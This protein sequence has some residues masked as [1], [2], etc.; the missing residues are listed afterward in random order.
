[1]SDSLTPVEEVTS[2]QLP[3]ASTLLS[4]WSDAP[5][6]SNVVHKPS[7]EIQ[8]QQPDA[9]MDDQIVLDNGNQIGMLDPE[10]NCFKI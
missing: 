2:K 6:V 9:N 5:P 4:T 3:D 7:S 8:G 1:M 10:C